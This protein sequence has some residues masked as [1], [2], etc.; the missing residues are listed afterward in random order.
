MWTR[1]AARVLGWEGISTLAPGHHADMIIVDRNPLTCPL[2][3]LP[4]TRVLRTLL[5]GETVYDAGVL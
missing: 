2:D 3:D 5:G 4:R 1:D